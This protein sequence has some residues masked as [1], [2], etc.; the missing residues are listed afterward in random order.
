MTQTPDISFCMIVRNGA[1]TLHACLESVAGIADEMIV[2]DTGSTDESP[3]I[4]QRFGARVVS[5]PWPHDFAAA[6]NTYLRL[7]R[8]A[9]VLSLDADEILGPVTRRAMHKNLAARP[10]MAFVFDIRNYHVASPQPQLIVHGETLGD[11]IAGIGQS[12]SR[13]VRLFPR[14]RGVEYCYPVHESLVPALKRCRVPF[15]RCPVPIHHLGHLRRDDMAAKASTYRELGI[16]KL[17]EHPEYFLAHLE[18][19]K[20]R[21]RD[22][23]LEAAEQLLQDCLRLNPRCSRAYYYLAIVAVQRQRLDTAAVHLRRARAISPTHSDIRHLQ[24]SIARLA[25]GGEAR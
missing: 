4:A 21:L 7:A 11:A 16:R 3:A 20:I 14:V 13:T 25:T 15:G 5:I 18:L 23:E 6:R 12:I 17:Q 24:H 2:V 10:R 22:G 8:C 19:A 1:A 9:W